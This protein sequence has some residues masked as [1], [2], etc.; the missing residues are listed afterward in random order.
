MR[1]LAF[2]ISLFLTLLTSACAPTALPKAE[3]L[4][5]LVATGQ[6]AGY[7]LENADRVAIEF[8][9]AWTRSD[10][11]EMHNLISFASREATPL[12]NFRSTYE[13]VHE[14][15]T[16][17][18]LNYL[19]VTSWRDENNNRVVVFSYSLHFKTRL[20][21]EFDDPAREL[22]LIF[23]DQAQN[24]RVAWS[25]GDIFKELDNGGQLRLDTTPVRR[26]NIYDR[27][28]KVLADMENPVVIVQVVKQQIEQFDI[29]MATLTE[30]LADTPIE[31]IQTRLDRAAPDWRTE[32]GTIEPAAYT[33]WQARLESDC[34]AT[35]DNRKTRWYHQGSLMPHILGA[36]GYLG[37][38]DI[39]AAQAAGFSQDA[40]LGR[41]GIEASQDE[42]LRGKPGARLLIVTPGGNILRE[43]A[44]NPVQSA[45]GVWLTIDS[46]LQQV[47]LDLFAQTYANTPGLT[48]TSK[49]GSAVVMNIHTGEILAMVSW[50][51]YDDNALTPFPAIGKQ[52]AQDIITK[53]NS[54][55][56]NPL[57]NRVTQGRY[58]SGSVMKIATTMAVL[59]S[60]VFDENTRYNCGGSWTQDNVTLFDWFPDGHGLVTP[61]TAITQSC[62]P[63]FYESGYRMNQRDIN[64]LPEYLRQLGMGQV[65]GITEIAEDSGYIGDA[66]TLRVKYGVQWSFSDASRMAI[67]QGEVEITPLQIV[68]LTAAIANGGSLYRPQLVMQTGILDEISYT[69]TPDANGNLNIRP[70]VITMVKEGMCQVTTE[71]YGTAEFIFRDSSLQEIGVCG[72]TGTAQDLPRPTTHAW[73]T[74]YAPRDNPE[75]AI[76]V[77]IENA[78]VGIS[79]EGSVM[80]APIVRQALEYYF[81]GTRPVSNTPTS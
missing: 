23:D 52:A 31:L 10:F 2:Q 28:G 33:Q 80:A 6:P 77:M 5:T 41:S 66:E 8:L 36:V 63:F 61:I 22:R 78:G 51:T 3:Q 76:T 18:A 59:D 27:D 75:I 48:D 21:G 17:E 62:N 15:M 58:P 60:G 39:P 67:G 4:P 50:P 45:E 11:D 47:L 38:A 37:E 7:G 57:L 70:E 35:F 9:D 12:V 32:V 46:D 19:P 29:C 34:N 73:F 69:L 26:G 24:W 53:L 74:A 49:G 55:E 79:G 42:L 65:T 25:Q 1:R 30:A 68:R 13:T 14:V 54:D 64:L 44:T 43:V 56:R 16:L 72:K 20:I 71:A 40:I 81:F